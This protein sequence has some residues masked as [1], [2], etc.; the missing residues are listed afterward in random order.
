MRSGSEG[1][2]SREQERGAG[3]T[4][5]REHKEQRNASGEQ[6]QE[7][8]QEQGAGSREQECEEQHNVCEIGASMLVA[9]RSAVEHAL[10]RGRSNPIIEQK[11]LY[12]IIAMTQWSL[13]AATGGKPFSLPDHGTGT[14]TP[15]RFIQGWPQWTQNHCP[16]HSDTH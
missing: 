3:S 8:E 16:A 7:Q 12:Y 2:R 5:S 10:Q 1:S 13:S 14:G 6:E 9:V 4:R 15:H 11:L